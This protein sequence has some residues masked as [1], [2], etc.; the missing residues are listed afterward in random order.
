MTTTTTSPPRAATV[1][2][3]SVPGYGHGCVSY[4]PCSHHA[5]CIPLTPHVHQV[6]TTHHT[7][8]TAHNPQNTHN[9][10][11]PCLLRHERECIGYLFP[12]MFHPSLCS[13]V[14][15][16]LQE[17]AQEHMPSQ[18]CASA[19]PTNPSLSSTC[20]GVC[21]GDRDSRIESHVD[22]LSLALLFCACCVGRCR[23]RSCWCNKLGC[24]CW[25]RCFRRAWCK[26]EAWPRWCPEAV[27]V[28]RSRASQATQCANHRGAGRR[29]WA[30]RCPCVPQGT[31]GAGACV[32]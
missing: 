14:H 18:V 6:R 25:R 23:I 13:P 16:A 9:V 3:P 20:L 31:Q 22:A 17:V 7:Q 28:L 27:L 21:M 32:H 30:L 12:G 4:H 24:Q 1:L 8:P 11:G 5:H 26:W 15:P 29:G 2:P 10:H 19:A